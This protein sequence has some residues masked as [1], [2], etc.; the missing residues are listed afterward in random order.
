MRYQEE[1]H[2]LERELR[3]THLHRSLVQ[4]H[5]VKREI[6]CL[7][8]QTEMI[9]APIQATDL[10]AGRIH[11]MAVGIDPERGGLTEAAYFCQFDR[12]NSMAADETTP[13][14]TRTNIHFL[15]DYWRR[16]ATVFKC[17]DAFTDDMKKGLPSDDYY[18]GREIAYPMYGLGGPCLDYTKLVNLGI[19]GLRK[20]VSQWK[21]INN[22]AAPYFYDSL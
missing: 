6:A 21:R 7:A 8:A 20:E 2:P 17:R 5:P 18:S 3:F 12:L 22:N 14:Q 19:P 16:E 15:L 13:P 9:F 10:F 1:I 4:S 11:P